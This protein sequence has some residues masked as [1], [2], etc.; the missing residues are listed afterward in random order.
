M[1]K[2]LVTGATGQ[3]G[4]LVVDALAQTLPATQIVAAARNTAKV[5][6]LA[7]RGIVVR[8]L[9]YDQPGTLEQAF[10][11][12]DKVLLISSSEVGKRAAQHLAVI[13][14][15][16]KAGVGLLAYTSLLHADRSALAL[17]VE[18][19]VTEEAVRSSGLPFVLLRNGWYT[20]NYI[21]GI[22]AALQY[23]ALL[24]SAKEG[25]I[26]SA[27]RRDFA[28]AA[29]AVLTAEESQA[30]KVYEL[31]GDESYTL[32]EFAAEVSRQSGVPVRYQDLSEADFCAALVR[33]GLPQS[34]ASLLSDSDAAASQGALYDEGHVLSSLIGRSTTPL[35]VAVAEALKVY[36]LRGG[37]P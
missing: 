2:I 14:A 21:A 17:A 12:V 4:R 3:L 22:P 18:H 30:G 23:G 5:G 16:K 8:E 10:S 20:E 19:L 32:A 7:A 24:G 35:R 26:S 37:Q 25:R 1:G 33:A 34:V 31:A 29:A 11:D 15:A 13:S 28:E 6:D 27:T 9:D 36:G